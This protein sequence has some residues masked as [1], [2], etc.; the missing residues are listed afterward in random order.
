ML[1]RRRRV[2]RV[3]RVAAPVALAAVALLSGCRKSVYH[4]LSE[5]R[6]NELV[7]ALERHGIQADKVAGSSDGAWKVTVP[8][9]SKVR[10]WKVLESEG[11]P[12]P[13][14][15]GYGEHYPTGG[16]IPTSNE[17]HVLYE[18]ATSQELRKT[19]LKVDGIVAA[20]VNLVLPE[21]PRVELRKS[22]DEKP[23]AS[24]LVKYAPAGANADG[25]PLDEGAIEKL[26]AGGVDDL[27]A[28]RVRVV[29]TPADVPEPS[30]Q[31]AELARIGPVAVEAGSKGL[32]QLIVG[33]MGVIIV[34]L[35]AG[36]VYLLWRRREDVEEE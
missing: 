29:T 32:V 13:K 34:I 4:G 31:S 7:V 9:G 15:E 2:A 20:Q 26:V 35:G 24:V 30:R 25:P 10:A 14:A 6:A 18:Y 23:R 27:E 12:K 11:L 17:Q 3:W 28:G 36:I 5:R 33:G 21:Q 8:N 22:D 19:L 16:L 1:E